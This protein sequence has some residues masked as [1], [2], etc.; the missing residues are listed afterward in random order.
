MLVLL[1]ALQMVNV[2]ADLMALLL[3]SMKDYSSDF[4]LAS[5]ME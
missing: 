3:V 2:S 4:S 5:S 1:S